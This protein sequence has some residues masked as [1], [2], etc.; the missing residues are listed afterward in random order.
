MDHGQR[1]PAR[2]GSCCLGTEV[3]V[4]FKL[5]AENDVHNQGNGERFF[6]RE[7]MQSWRSSTDSRL[8]PA[9]LLHAGALPCTCGSHKG[10]SGAL[11]SVSV[12]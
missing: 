9:E 4:S 11:C 12:G 3:K 1:S 2:C 8:Q 5:S 6:Q 10:E 7:R